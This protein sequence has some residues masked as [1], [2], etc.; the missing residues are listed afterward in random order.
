MDRLRVVRVELVR[1]GGGRE[2]VASLEEAY[3]RIARDP[4]G[5]IGGR[6]ERFSD[7]GTF[8]ADRIV[9]GCAAQ[10][11]FAMKLGPEVSVTGQ[12]RVTD[13]SVA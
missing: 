1:P 12:G 6:I 5:Y 9:K 4:H 3:Q 7:Q 10:L 8:Q 11:W 2:A 13:Q